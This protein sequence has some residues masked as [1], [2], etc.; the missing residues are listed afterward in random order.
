MVEKARKLSALRLRYNLPSHE[1]PP[2]ADYMDVDDSF[3][4][5]HDVNAVNR[6]M[7]ISE[8]HLREFLRQCLSK[9]EKAKVEPGS[10]VGAVGAQSIGEPGTQMTL[11]TFHFAGV[12]S[13]NVT[14]GV[15]RI[16][17]II[18]ASKAISTPI[19]TCTLVTEDD[20][21]AARIVKGRIEKTYLEDIISYIED[22]CSRDDNYISI[23]LDQETISK[24]QLELTIDDIVTALVKAKLKIIRQDI[25]VIGNRIRIYVHEMAEKDRKRTKDESDVFLRVQ[26]LKRALPRV[27][28]KGYPNAARA[29]VK[30]DDKTGKNQILVEGYGLKL[31]MNTDGVVGTKTKSNSIMEMREVLGIEAARGSIIDEISYTM[32]EHGMDI[33][34]RHM[35]LLG[36]VMTY[37][38]EV[39]G[40]T[41]FGL[42]KMRDSVLQLAS[43]EKTTDHLFEAAFHMKSDAVEGVSECIILGQSMSIGTGS[44]KVVRRLMIDPCD[45]VPKKLVFEEAYAKMYHHPSKKPGRGR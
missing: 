24:L 40:I 41:R 33:D 22:V 15:P 19:I 1:E 7:K 39:L 31:C 37:K 5:A 32:R 34:P 23:R 36:D 13:M 4:L 43:F 27:V 25:R 9:Y 38:G 28:V 20:E 26:N 8:K 11:K 10:A 42:A 21:R 35:Q 44:F 6:I 3:F 29:V 45:L 30:K 14:L 17:E 12:A 18:N 16:K 2:D